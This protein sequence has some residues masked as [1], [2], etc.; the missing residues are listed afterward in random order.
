MKIKQ[1]TT[2][3]H[4]L[5]WLLL[6]A[7]LLGV[8]QGVWAWYYSG[9]TNGWNADA[10][11][12]GGNAGANWDYKTLTG[13]G[14][15]IEFKFRPN[16]GNWDGNI[17][18]GAILNVGDITLSGDD[19]CKCK[20]DNDKTF[21][22]CLLKSNSLCNNNNTEKICAT[23][24]DPSVSTRT[25]D[26]SEIMY[27]NLG[28]V[29]FWLSDNA[30]HA[31]YFFNICGGVWTS[32]LT[33]EDGNIYKSAV[34]TGNWSHVVLVRLKNDCSS[35]NWDDKWNQTR[36]IPI[37]ASKNYIS[38][39]SNNS[40]TATWGTYTPPSCTLP[41]SVLA[42]GGT[43][44]YLNTPTVTTGLTASYSGGT[45]DQNYKWEISYDP[46]GT[47]SLD[48]ISSD[49]P[50]ASFTR[51]GT[52]KFKVRVGCNVE[53]TKDTDYLL[54]N[55]IT[56][57]VNK[58]NSTFYIKHP[59]TD[60]ADGSWGWQGLTADD[61]ICAWTYIGKYGGTARCNI[62]TGID[63]EANSRYYA[64]DSDQETNISTVGNPNTG[65]LC[66]FK[67]VPSTAG[68][69]SGGAVTITKRTTY[70]VTGAV[71][72]SSYGS[73][74]RSPSD[75]TVV[76]GD[77]VTLTASP[78]TGYEVEKWMDGSTK[79]AD[80]VNS[81]TVSNVTANKTITVHFKC[82]TPVTTYNVTGGG[83]YCG[84][85]VALGLSG[86]ESGYKYRLIKDNN[87]ESPIETKTA[88]NNSGIAFTS[89]SAGGTYTVQVQSGAACSWTDVDDG[90]VNS[91][92][93]NAGAKPT[94][95]TTSS[96]TSGPTATSVT[97]GGG[98]TDNTYCT[99]TDAGIALYADNNNSKGDL[100]D[101]Y[102]TGTSSTTISKAF[103]SGLT[104][105]AKYW[106]TA[107]AT[108]GIGTQE[109][110]AYSFTMDKANQA[111]NPTI[112][113]IASPCGTGNYDLSATGGSGT[114]K[115]HYEVVTDGTT[116]GVAEILYNET[117]NVE[118]K[119]T[120]VGVIK[121][122]AY[123][124]GD[125]QYYD[126]AYGDAKTFTFK[127]AATAADFTVTGAGTQYYTGDPISVSVTSSAFAAADITAVKYNGSTTA[128][129]APGTYP[130]T[131]TTNAN[132]DYC[133]ATNLSLGTNLVIKVL[134]RVVDNKTS[135]WN[136]MYLY[137]WDNND[138][139]LGDWPGSTMT[140]AQGETNVWVKELDCLPVNI[141]F[142]CGENCEQTVD[143]GYAED[144]KGK[145]FSIIDTQT[146]SKY[147]VEDVTCNCET[148][149]V[150]NPS[151][152]NWSKCATVAAND[153]TISV[154]GS[155][156]TGTLSY[157]WFRN[158]VNQVAGASAVTDMV[159][160]AH[161]GNAYTLSASDM[162]T[163]YYYCVVRSEGYCSS[164]SATSGLTGALEI[165]QT[166]TLTPA[167]VTVKQYEPVKITANNAS[168]T[169]AITT[170]AAN[171]DMYFLYDVTKTSVTFKGDSHGGSGSG[172]EYDYVIT[173]TPVSETGCNATATIKVQNDAAECQ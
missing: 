159:D 128:P 126:S 102:T 81:Y 20:V 34:P 172:T 90:T 122:K 96:P 36:D 44:L 136:D 169:W 83:N 3:K 95:T 91:V 92:T 156:G 53:G 18:N 54:S 131:V 59:W 165:K 72:N 148:P 26:G 9:T 121:V 98:Y 137:Q 14:N 41:S 55:E 60:G 132:S 89:Q 152:G 141:I 106:Y 74:S 56:V 32:F 166:P 135:T 40:A 113:N 8:S 147:N 87:T 47:A 21:Y 75:G 79:V 139:G 31:A 78:N 4:K 114:G 25:F 155:S 111:S 150:T 71:N 39:F 129:T 52:Y 101:Y 116:T 24:T 43:T 2:L 42:S 164:K 134:I 104:S 6:L 28:A 70:T 50:T 168:V 97:L 125:S 151:S 23:T 143:I 140:L 138:C 17:G 16:S 171:S 112:G 10:L 49:S 58:G 161:G 11:S 46:S 149:S 142:N 124:K 61:N 99:T 22:V 62:A 144:H 118:L 85:A 33:Q 12:A 120:Q 13:T 80:N 35:P 86:S 77:D 119:V 163:Y 64:S 82:S 145:C 167:S 67:Y 107:Y 154:T 133:A 30:K 66:E 158:T 45:G 5:Q 115:Y 103:T 160:E 38:S 69:T 63:P 19:N 170:P 48:D 88:S 162:G 93:I 51:T 15:D 109:G 127:N 108:N 29:D 123:R 73:V 130:I 76:S 68:S 84:T 1:L 100:I 157:Q 94:V 110:T 105:G 37:D 57:T 153:R 7:A 65:D 117:D 173:A 27:F 146:D